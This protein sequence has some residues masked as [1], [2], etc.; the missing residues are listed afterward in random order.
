M[1]MDGRHEREESGAHRLAALL[2][3]DTIEAVDRDRQPPAW[4]RL[5][6]AVQAEVSRESRRPRR[7]R[8]SL[9]VGAALGLALLVAGLLHGDRPPST[10]VSFRVDGLSS[11]D[12]FV[13]SGADNPT[14]LD[15][16]D[17]SKVVLNP[18]GRLRV[19]DTTSDGA[20]LALERGEVDLSIQHRPS[21]HWQVAV[22]RYLIAVTGTRFNVSWDPDKGQ[23][24]VDMVDGAVRV[25]G[26]GIGAPIELRTGQ[27]FTAD[28]GRYTIRGSSGA[29]G[30][31]QAAREEGPPAGGDDVVPGT[32]PRQVADGPSPGAAP[33]PRAG[34]M[35]CDWVALVSNGRFAATLD[36]AHGMG[37]ETALARCPVR[38]LFAL[39]DA[40]RYRQVFDVSG[41]ALLAIRRR[42]PSDAGKAAFFLG[43][44]EEAR[45][46]YREALAWY[47]EVTPGRADRDF[48]AEAT[49]ARARVADRIRTNPA[50]EIH[51]GP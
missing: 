12:A 24:A 16:S 22:G 15:F 11:G 47:S 45:G 18:S 6:L 10:R 38:S 1:S 33:L 14:K 7:W 31:T 27:K 36:R 20:A 26:P 42:S 37:I 41:E 35:S 3:S 5:L 43:R 49:A 21:T 9:A 34:R 48:V 19:V 4:P 50:P 44:L 29:P 28:L 46:R 30:G 17:G 51:V 39:A 32:A 8:W 40:A 25:Q 23:I 2:R 13:S